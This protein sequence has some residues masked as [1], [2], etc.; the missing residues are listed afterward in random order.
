MTRQRGQ[1]QRVLTEELLDHVAGSDGGLGEVL[2]SVG[3]LLTSHR[4]PEQEAEGEQGH[5]TDQS[6]RSQKHVPQRLG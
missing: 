5:G 4:A 1:G 6:E 3:G 2:G